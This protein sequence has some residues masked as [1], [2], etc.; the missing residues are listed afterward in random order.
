MQK[1]LGYFFWFFAIYSHFFY[2]K[3]LDK[4]LLL[5]QKMNQN[6]PPYLVVPLD[7]TNFQK[8]IQLPS[9]QPSYNKQ[10]FDDI[11]S[12]SSKYEMSRLLL[13]TLRVLSCIRILYLHIKSKSRVAG[14]FLTLLFPIALVLDTILYTSMLLFFTIFTSIWLPIGYLSRNIPIGL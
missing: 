3:D 10:V 1:K 5:L 7:N 8:N 13:I 4:Y 9:Y 12:Y 11:T 6:L 2:K 14:V